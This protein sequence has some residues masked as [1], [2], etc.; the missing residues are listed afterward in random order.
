MRT[1]AAVVGLAAVMPPTLAA[2]PPAPAGTSAPAPASAAPQGAQDLSQPVPE[3]KLTRIFPNVTL[4]RPTQAVQA[5]GEP[6][7]LY[8]IEQAGRILRL[9]DRN[10]QVKS[11]EVFADLR[12]RVN[13]KNNEEGLLSICF[14][15]R[16][17]DNG[18]VY[19]Y[20]TAEKPRRS[21]LSRFHVNND[22]QTLDADSELK[23]LEVEQP[24][25]NHN[26]GTILFDAQGMLYLSLG[27][28]GAANDP[29]GNG[30]NLGSLL[31]KILRLDV[32]NATKAAP[33]AVPA[34]NPF[35]ATRGARKEIWAYGLR[36]VWRMSFDRATGR[37]WAGDVGQNQYE[38]IDLI[39]KGGNY[40]WNPRE[41]LHAFAPGKKG[42]FGD[43]Y[44]DPLFEYPHSDGVSVTGGYVYRGA[45]HPELDGVYFF[46]DY[47]YGIIWGARTSG[48]VLGA[49]R[50][51]IHRSGNLWTSFGEMLDGE[52][53]LCS[54]D[55]GE[56]GPGSLWKIAAAR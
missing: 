29:H 56:H 7:F 35:I 17:A 51:L 13:D 24:Y 36:N 25:A 42:D 26:G 52:L 55:G 49:P 21:I 27:D 38:E 33:Y 23:I 40:G 41:G 31:G 4:R 34:D 54:F 10:D 47:G 5:P 30:Q 45:K 16:Y 12:K 39:V 28:G 18:F 44:I 6:H 15:P 19:L 43:A 3:I 9:D 32:R 50:K 1:P 37:L 46:A 8:V 22:R 48:A 11:G 2:A 14:D 20:Y 53:V